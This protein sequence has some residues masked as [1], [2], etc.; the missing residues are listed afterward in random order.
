MEISINDYK[1]K[2]EFLTY[3]L[4]CKFNVNLILAEYTSVVGLNFQKICII[5]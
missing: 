4:C 5:L 2:L 3:F 1:N